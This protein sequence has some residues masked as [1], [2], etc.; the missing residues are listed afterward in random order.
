MCSGVF[1]NDFRNCFFLRSLVLYRVSHLKLV[2]S[3]P[4]AKLNQVGLLKLSY[5]LTQCIFDVVLALFDLVI[6]LLL[7]QGTKITNFVSFIIL[8]KYKSG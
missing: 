6:Q 1:I 7:E 3:R 4:D 5:V 8:I 2:F